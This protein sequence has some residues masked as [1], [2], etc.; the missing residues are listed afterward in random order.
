MALK[1]HSDVIFEVEL[2]LGIVGLGLEVHNEIVL[3]SED[4]VD[5]KMR[6][7]VGVDLVDDRGVIRVCNHKV[8]MCG[9]HGRTVHDIKE[10]TGRAV[11]GQRVRCGVVAVPPIFSV[12]IC[13]EFTAEVVFALLG[14]LEII[15]AVGGGLPNVEN[16]TDDRLSGLHICDDTVHEGDFA[17]RIG[18]LDNAIAELAEWGIG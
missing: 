8:N 16:G 2:C 18:V 3:D 5:G 11:G 10:N 17:R 7:V 14:V 6:V 15:F 9:A 1:R 12:L 13:C 4:G